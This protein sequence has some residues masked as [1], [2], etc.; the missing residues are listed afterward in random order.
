MRT[1][2]SS[3]SGQAFLLL[4]LLLP[5]DAAEVA[6][7]RT[8]RELEGV[9]R[10]L[11]EGTANGD[12]APWER[13]AAED[14]LYTTEFGRTLTKAELRALFVPLPAQERRPLRLHVIGLRT[15]AGAAVLVYDLQAHEAEGVERY[16]VTDTY[17]RVEG[18][19]RLVASQVVRVEEGFE[20]GGDKAGEVDGNE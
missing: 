9:A 17:W 2:L 7:A 15:A 11:H 8:D 10:A 14:L 12:W 13:H 19:W 1:T 18:R 4:C 16:R 6:R 20:P 5:N 3:W